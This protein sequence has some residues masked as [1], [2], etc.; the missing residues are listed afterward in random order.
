MSDEQSNDAAPA[1][2]E[3][4]ANEPVHARYVG[5]T[6]IWMPDLDRRAAAGISRCCDLHPENER[7]A[8]HEAWLAGD[9]SQDIAPRTGFDPRVVLEH[10]DV[11][12]LDRHTATERGDFELIDDP[13]PSRPRRNR[14]KED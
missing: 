6:R 8:E 2:A 14:S 10:G 9:P 5:E 11:L 4:D 3:A 1:V 12:V 7:D 13:E